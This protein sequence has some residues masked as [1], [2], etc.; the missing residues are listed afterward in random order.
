MRTSV[1]HVAGVVDLGVVVGE[2]ADD[3]VLREARDGAQHLGL[4]EVAV[5]GHPGRAPAGPAEDVVEGHAGADV[6]A[7]VDR[8]AQG[9]EEAHRLDQ[10][11]GEA[12]QQEATLDQRL[13]HEAEVELLEV[14][15]AAV[16]E[17]R[18][19]ARRARPPSR[20]PRRCR[21]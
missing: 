2:A 13:A 9:V 5:V 3:G 19:P 4:A 14:A 10:V 1:R 21:R 17:L 18:R 11:R 15:D 16:H 6:E 8:L 7:L 20:A 12:L